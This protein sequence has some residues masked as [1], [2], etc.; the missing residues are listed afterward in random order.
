VLDWPKP[1]TVREVQAFLGFANFYRRFIEGYSRIAK[2]LTELTRKDQASVWTKEAEQA[3]LELKGR[4]T[5]APILCMFDPEKRI[6]LEPDASGYAIGA[7]LSQPDEQ[8]KLRPNAYHSRKLAPAELNYEIHDKELLAIVEAFKQW[9]VYLEGSRYPVKVWTDHKNLIYF[10]TTKVLNKRQVRWSEALSAFNFNIT[11]R[12]GSENA[13]ADALS[14]RGDY[15]KTTAERP[16]AILKQGR[17]G[18][19]V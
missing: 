4:F 2:P 16:Q 13:R 19:R 3:F 18:I 10:T 7:C 14:R 6:I 15:V 12:K 8:G 9:R 17:D 1:S 5:G 11:H